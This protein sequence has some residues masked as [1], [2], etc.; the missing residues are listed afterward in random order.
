M[1]AADLAC[2]EVNEFLSRLRVIDNF[3][4]PRPQFVPHLLK[5]AGQPAAVISG[6]SL[7]GDSYLFEIIGGADELGFCFGF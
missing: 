3:A 7:R 1:I 2:T 4:R 6:I 5:I